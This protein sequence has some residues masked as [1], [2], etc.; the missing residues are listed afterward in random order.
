MPEGHAEKRRN[1]ILDACST[2]YRNSSF[3]DVT[4]KDISAYTSMSRPSIYNYFRTAEEIFLGLLE[5]EYVR[6]E[7]DLDIIY[8]K[9]RLNRE[10]LA[11]ALSK[12][13][14]ERTTLLRIQATNLHE[15]ED[16]SRLERLTEFK[17]TLC[18][19][20]SLMDEILQKF[21]PGMTEE[22]RTSFR[23]SFFAFLSGVYPYTDSTEKQQ[24]AME[25]AGIPFRKYSIYE[26]VYPCLRKLLS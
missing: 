23:V 24:R 4:M 21:I 25:E 13:L 12:S 3:H 8:E 10:E 19:V 6:W 9:E 16:N 7:E 15:I 2:L 14:E 26:I 1:E 17:R 20:F 22:E 5:R 18:G 11:D